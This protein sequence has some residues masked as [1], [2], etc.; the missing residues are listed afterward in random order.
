MLR[1]LGANRNKLLSQFLPPHAKQTSEYATVSIYIGNN[2]K[3]GK[4]SRERFRIL[5]I[6][7]VIRYKVDK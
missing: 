2:I 5:Q 1:H 3:D 4:R 6:I 7:Y